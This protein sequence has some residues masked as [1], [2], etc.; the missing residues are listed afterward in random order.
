MVRINILYDPECCGMPK[1][2]RGGFPGR[3]E[4]FFI[5][6]IYMLFIYIVLFN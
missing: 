2:F 1:T 4:Y 5:Y 6:I 3:R